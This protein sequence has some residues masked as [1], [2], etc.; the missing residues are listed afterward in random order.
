MALYEQPRSNCRVGCGLMRSARRWSQSRWIPSARIFAATKPLPQKRLRS[1]T[2]KASKASK[3]G[4]FTKFGKQTLFRLAVRTYNE[5]VGHGKN[6]RDAISPDIGQIFVGFRI[7]HT[8]QR[9][10]S[11][12]HNDVN[13]GQ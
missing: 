4:K 5:V 13:R 1:L 7:H 6:I 8:F 10:V 9:H 2:A 3:P 11:V 12:I